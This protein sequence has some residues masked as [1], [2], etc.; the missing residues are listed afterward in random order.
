MGTAAAVMGDKIT[1]TCSGHQVPNPATGAPQP[2]PPMPFSAPLTQ[3]LAST[4][5]IGNKP[6][7][8]AGSSGLNIPPHVGLHPSDPFLAPSAQQGTVAAG[9]GTVMF[10]GQPA[11]KTGVSCTVCFGAPGQLAGTAAT[12]LIGG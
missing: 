6:A 3:G 4:V 9:S 5:L 1:A 11:A 7:A 8:V 12:V 10:D 2:A